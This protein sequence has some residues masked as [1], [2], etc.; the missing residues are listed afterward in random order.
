MEDIAKLLEEKSLED[1]FKFINHLV[2]HPTPENIQTLRGLLLVRD[3]STFDKHTIPKYVA[4]MFLALGENG[5]Q[6]LATLFKKAPGSIYPTSILATLF[7][8]SRKEYCDLML[9]QSVRDDISQVIK[10][11]IISDT[12]AM[13][14]REIFQEI[15]AESQSDYDVFSH[16]IAFID[17]KSTAYS[18]AKS[19]EVD[20][21]VRAIFDIFTESSISI[22]RKIIEEFKKLVFTVGL[23]EE[24]YQKYLSQHPV[25]L[26]SLAKTTISKQK[27]GVD[28]ITDFVIKKLNGEYVIVEIEKPSDLIFTKNNDFTS[29]FTHALGQI[30]DFQEW[31]ESNIAYAQKLMP[32]IKSPPGLLVIGRRDQLND[33][34]QNKLKRFNI[35]SNGRVKVITFDD[36]LE[37]AEHLYRNIHS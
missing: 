19:A 25:L 37:N 32:N 16:L 6:E 5:L 27:L 15:V 7:S 18:M 21:M 29:Q 30:I 22:N 11:P 28:L 34:Q 23:K 12:M 33:Y 20:E 13:R 17:Q 3:K 31:T 14:A 26:D 10:E 2:E 1:L 24:E 8:A 35:N 9:F 4:R 36:I